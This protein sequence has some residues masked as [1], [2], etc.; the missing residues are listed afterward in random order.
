[1]NELDENIFL[2]LFK[3]A[4]YKCFGIPLTATLS[5]TESKHFS[6]IIFDAT[7]LVIGAKSLKNYSAY[8]TDS[9]DG[10]KENP[11][12]ATLDTLARYVLH[13]PY[14]NETT[15]KDKEG[16]FPYW[17]QYKTKTGAAISIKKDLRK[18]KHPRW[19][20]LLPLLLVA[21]IL[22]FISRWTHKRDDEQFTD[23][24]QTLN[25]D[26]LKMKGWMLQSVD[27]AWWKRRME[28][29]GTLT[30]FTLKGDNWPDSLM[31]QK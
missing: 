4:S 21:I 15:R 9:N 29:P 28:M 6:N 27:S 22:F 18:K 7:G 3:E 5:E 1:M 24:F 17:F 31:H 25:D 13:A 30:L 8:V 10:K 14:T 16:H 26:S 12:V 23:T 19:L 2:I 20:L 11:S